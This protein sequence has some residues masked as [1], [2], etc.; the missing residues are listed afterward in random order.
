MGKLH[1]HFFSVLNHFR[2]CANKR[3]IKNVSS[4]FPA[5]HRLVRDQYNCEGFPLVRC[6]SDIKGS[7][8]SDLSTRQLA[9]L[10]CLSNSPDN[11]YKVYEHEQAP[12]KF[13]DDHRPR[14]VQALRHACAAW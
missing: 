3:L 8:T 4:L 11:R 7:I 12:K 13:E 10:Q 14:F 2:K 5:K 1:D 9:L 6:I